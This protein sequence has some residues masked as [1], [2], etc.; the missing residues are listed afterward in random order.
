[1]A[2]FHASHTGSHSL[3][4]GGDIC[5]RAM[6]M[7]VKESKNNLSLEK[8]NSFLPTFLTISNSFLQVFSNFSQIF[9]T[10]FANF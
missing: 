1:M 10:V 7:L 8:I 2:I 6:D 9:L 5:G 3:L 4:F